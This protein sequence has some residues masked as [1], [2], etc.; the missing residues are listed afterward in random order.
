MATSE[1]RLIRAAD[2]DAEAWLCRPDDGVAHPGLLFYMD[3]L[4]V[5]TALVAMARRL[6]DL[7]YVVLLPDLFYRAGPRAPFDPAVALTDPGER[8][9]LFA[10]F[11]SIDAARV[12]RDTESYVATLRSAAPTGTI[13]CLGYCMGGGFA[14]TAAATYPEIVAAAASIH[15]ANVATDRPD[16]PHRLADRIQGRVYAAVAEID[17]WLAPGET[18]RLREA[19]VSARVAHRIEIFPGA[20]HGFAVDDLPVYERAAAERHWHDVEN[21]FG[22][23]LPGAAGG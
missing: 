11:A 7:G 21:L 12:M 6:A 2:G 23:T 13:G 17:P 19:L 20:Q 22:E 4:G 3:G 8:E 16:S 5:R 10:L 15:G 1:R 9:R 14:L 18:A